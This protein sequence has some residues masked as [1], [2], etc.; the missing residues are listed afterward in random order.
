MKKFAVLLSAIAFLL[1]GC[2]KDEDLGTAPE[3]CVLLST[4]SIVLGEEVTISNCSKDALYS[5]IYFGDGTLLT[6]ENQ[7]KHTFTESGTFNVTVIAYPENPR[8]DVSKA[9]KTITVLPYKEGE[10]PKACFTYRTQSNLE[11]LFVNCSENASVFEWDFGDGNTGTGIN[12]VHAYSSAG[13]YTVK[14]VAKN[15]DGS[16]SD[17]TELQVTIVEVGEPKACFDPSVTSASPDDEI[18]FINCSE[19]SFQFEWDFGNGEKSTVL[20]PTISYEKAGTYTVKLKAYSADGKDFDEIEEEISIGDKF[21]IAIRIEGFDNEKGNGGT[22]DPD[23]QLPF[24]I[25]GLGAEPDPKMVFGQGRDLDETDVVFDVESGDLPIEWELDRGIKIDDSEWTFT[26]IDDDGFLGEEEMISWQQS[27]KGL[28]E[29][30]IIT[31]ES[32]DFEVHLVYE[33]R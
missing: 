33:I 23:I 25:D 20:N 26:M 9:E 1:Y 18:S 16:A 2:G 13:D 7:I 11:V 14:L 27:L 8:N 15:R 28:G 32:G 22:W 6:K 31:L 21:L 29:D 19:N 3:A 10:S 17:E 5:E 4:E 24:P 30:G 12:P